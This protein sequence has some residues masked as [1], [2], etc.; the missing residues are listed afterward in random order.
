MQDIEIIILYKKPGEEFWAIWGKPF[1]LSDWY[2]AS[3]TKASLKRSG[4][5]I[6]E[7]RF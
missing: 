3:K 5:Q 6:R 4:F 2:T 1:A 7:Q